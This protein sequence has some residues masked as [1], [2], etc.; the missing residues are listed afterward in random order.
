MGLLMTAIVSFLGYKNG[1]W[2]QERFFQSQ[3]VSFSSQ[4]NPVNIAVAT[5]LHYLSS[6]LTDGGAFFTD[7]VENADG[8]NM[9]YI[10]EITES[11]VATMIQEK[12]EIL[13]LSGDLTFNGE[14]QSH[15]D[16]EQKLEKIKENG[17]QIL[18]MPGNHDI[19]RSSAAGFFGDGYQ[20]VD[21]VSKEAFAKI[22]QDYGLQE[23][24][25]KDDTSL[26]Y[27][28]RARKDFW[29]LMLDSNSQGTNEI[30]DQTFSWIEEILKD[31]REQDIQVLAVSHQNLLAHNP[32]FTEGFLIDQAQELEALYQQYAVVANLSG[33]IHIQ[34]I[35]DKDLP[36]ILTSALPVS[37]HHYGMIQ[38]D[39]KTLDY[40]TKILDVASW[41][42]GQ[43]LTDQKLLN[44]SQSSQA[45][46]EQ[47]AARKLEPDL[48]DSSLTDLERELLLRTFARV[49]ADYFAGRSIDPADHQQGLSLLQ[50]HD[51]PFYPSYIDSILKSAEK[52]HESLQLEIE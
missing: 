34:H 7:L 14:R 16:L 24:I 23:S 22:Y 15:L 52:G 46:M 32:Y 4:E 51:L 31:A 20:L 12:P 40:Q 5:D 50:D 28:Y 18:V 26:S 19:D 27:L 17:T 38:F 49:N 42:R 13:I 33:H 30:S 9:F 10:E 43:G 1:N 41:A 47:V 8:K 6:S 11:F 3:L 48:L 2:N 25:D 35:Q 21:T 37:P 39:G 36:E 29:I 44:F 45:F